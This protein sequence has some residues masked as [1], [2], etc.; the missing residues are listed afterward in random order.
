MSNMSYCRFE[1]TVDD[2]RDCLN[3]LTDAVESG[4]SFDQFLESLS[5]DYERKGVRSMA[6]VLIDM[7]EAFEQLHD[8]EGLSAEELEDL[9]NA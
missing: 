6:N 2:M 8:N 4:L 3:A 9:E 1:N 7:A 5:S